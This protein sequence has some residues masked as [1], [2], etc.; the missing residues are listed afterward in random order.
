[1][2]LDIFDIRTLNLAV[3]EAPAP[4]TFLIN[5]FFR[6]TAPLDT[7]SVDIDIKKRGKSKLAPFVSPMSNGIPMRKSGFETTNVKPAYIHLQ[8]PFDVTELNNR[9]AGESPYSRALSPSERLAEKVADAL[10]EKRNSIAARVEYM[11]AQAIVEGKTVI[12]GEGVDREIDYQRD[13]DLSV[14]LTLGDR[15]S[16]SGSKPIS[17][18]RAW[19]KQLAM[20]GYKPDTVIFG[21]NAMSAF[22]ANTEVKEYFQALG[23]NVA[24]LKPERDDNL[25]V[26]KFAAPA[27]FATFFTYGEYYLDEDTSEITPLIPEDSVIVADSKADNRFYHGAIANMKAGGL[28]AMSEFVWSKDDENG[29][30][31]EVH[32]ESSPLPALLHPNSVLVAKVL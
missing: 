3:Q 23:Y 10:V 32:I 13:A 25:G 20:E 4:K 11:A 1:M 30:G 26:V 18:L 7:T 19:F 15:W 24:A 17:D 31:T 27:E 6:T 16:Q 12:K 5:R 8:T 2:S 9:I 29:K 28:V 21:D 14:E 22:L